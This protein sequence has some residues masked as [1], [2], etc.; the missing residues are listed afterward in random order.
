M[1]ADIII[2]LFL[3]LFLL[4]GIKR[5]FAR[6]LLNLLGL[7]VTAFIAGIVA[8]FLSELIYSSFIRQ[9]LISNIEASIEQGGF[10]QTLANC[11]DFLP[12]WIYSFVY[13]L[14]SLFGVSMGEVQKELISGKASQATAQAVESVISPLITAVISIALFFIVSVVIFVLLKVFVIRYIAKIFNLPVIKQINAVLGGI[15]GLAEGF[16]LVWLAVNIISL[17]FA[18]TDNPSVNSNVFSGP[19]FGFFAV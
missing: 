16:I 3:A 6:G 14:F 17:I 5:G 9:S 4:A 2:I 19:I 1:I 10:E 8:R 11:L 7:V 12:S 15:F 18:A 13:A